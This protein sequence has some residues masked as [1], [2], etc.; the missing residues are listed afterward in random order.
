MFGIKLKSEKKD[1]FYS[2]LFPVKRD[3]VSEKGLFGRCLSEFVD[4]R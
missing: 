2:V 4:W 1:V 3:A